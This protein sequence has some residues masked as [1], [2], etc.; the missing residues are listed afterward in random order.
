MTGTSNNI[1]IFRRHGLDNL[2]TF[3]T[4]PVT[5]HHTA[6]PY[7][8]VGAWGFKSVCFGAPSP[9]L[10]G[11]NMFDQ[12]FFMGLF[13]W[14]SGHISAQS[15]SRSSP[16][17][18]IK[19]KAL[20]LGVPA[21]VHSFLVHPVIQAFL[22][23]QWDISS[24]CASV[25]KSWKTTR[26]LR[27]PVWYAGT[28]LAFD[29]AAAV[30]TKLGYLSTRK[31]KK[32]SNICVAL[33]R[34]GWIGVAAFSFLVR[35]LYP[36]GTTIPFLNLQPAYVSQYIYAY[37]LGVLSY[38]PD[39]DRI[40]SPLEFTSISPLTATSSSATQ[41]MIKRRGDTALVQAVTMS[42]STMLLIFLS[43]YLSFPNSRL[44]GT[45]RD[46]SG[47]AN[48]TAFI[49]AVWNEFSFAILAPT[50][51]AYFQPWHSQPTKSSVLVPRASYAA[52]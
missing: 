38:R 23:P 36:V 22:Q 43:G 27:G 8:G 11:L 48:R 49:Y 35:L 16:L 37:L 52:F 45:I 24:I 18:F 29:I 31:S 47:G 14:I 28:L 34:Y 2:R 42:L 5:V 44:N 30:A 6:I 13:F 51:M 19:S 32:R 15:L 41:G 26:G 17:S 4:G 20:R 33:C 25:L 3:L 21:L 39:E 7:G 50:L 12:S 40:Y 10:M 1:I 9:V 46:F